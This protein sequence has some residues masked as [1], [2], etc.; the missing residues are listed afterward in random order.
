MNIAYYNSGVGN[1]VATTQQL[2]SK[3]FN[4]MELGVNYWVVD[5]S[6]LPEKKYR[7]AWRVDNEGEITLDQAAVDEINIETATQYSSLEFF[8]RFTPPEVAG[9]Y[10]QADTVQDTKIWIDQMLGANNVNVKDPM[11]IQGMSYLVF[12]GLIT[13]DRYNEI[14]GI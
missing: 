7:N 2:D 1:E 12:Q 6:N 11:T 13:Q 8:R 4:G 3:I 9:I 5:E 10:T 14:L